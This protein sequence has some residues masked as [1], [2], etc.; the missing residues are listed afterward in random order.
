[1]DKSMNRHQEGDGAFLAS[2][3]DTLKRLS[4]D[5]ATLQREIE[6]ATGVDQTT[7][8]RAMNGR[9]RRVTE[10]VRRISKYANMRERKMQLPQEIHEAAAAFLHA[11]GQKDELLAFIRDATRLIV[12]TMRTDGP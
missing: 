3:S 10:K 6:A 8:S 12:R 1:M 9:L 7:I 11:G 4:A 2:L 5:K